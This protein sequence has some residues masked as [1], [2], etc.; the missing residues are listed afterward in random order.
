M[1]V[2]LED[3]RTLRIP[4]LS[5]LPSSVVALFSRLWSDR[6]PRPL[7]ERQPGS[8]RLVIWAQC[9]HSREINNAMGALSATIRREERRYPYSGPWEVHL[10]GRQ[11]HIVR[12]TV[13]GKIFAT[14]EVRHRVHW[15]PSSIFFLSLGIFG[16]FLIAISDLLFF[17]FFARS[18]WDCSHSFFWS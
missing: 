12:D 11:S 2:N 6:R 9:W 1:R 17:L 16:S 8:V 7:F 14:S 5:N 13:P 4:P 15:F 18:I 3:S 10:M